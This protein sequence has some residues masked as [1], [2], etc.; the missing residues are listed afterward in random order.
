MHMM[1]DLHEKISTMNPSDFVMEVLE[2]SE[3]LFEY[4]D[5][6]DPEL[7][8][9]FENQNE[10]I[11]GVKL[12]ENYNEGATIEDFLQE[13]S[14]L[15]DIDQWEDTGDAVTLMTIHSAKGLEFRHV[16]IAGMEE[17][18]FPLERTRLN[19][20]EL[21]EERRLF[22]VALTR[23]MENVTITST[24][25]RMR[26]GTTM[27]ATPS[28]FLSEIPDK[29]ID[30]QKVKRKYSF[31]DTGSSFGNRSKGTQSHKSDGRSRNPEATS[32]KKENIIITPIKTPT[33]GSISIGD[34]VAHKMFGKGRVRS[35][36]RSSQILLKIEF[37]NGA[38]KTIAEKFIEK[39]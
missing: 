26:F 20:K 19:P 39:V 35:I 5:K 28:L 21:E 32:R 1:S 24:Q 36:I 30:R 17:G 6:K 8:E 7:R 34:R 27:G 2:Q 9:R 16:F 38:N 25:M 22:Y 14:L 4:Q 10:F 37:D 23:A 12:F 33:P 11:N 3:L 29:Y 31:A 13:V 15:S 18:L